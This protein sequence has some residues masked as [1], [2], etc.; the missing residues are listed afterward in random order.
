MKEHDAGL[1]LLAGNGV[2]CGFGRGLEMAHFGHLVGTD[3]DS[4]RLV[5]FVMM[6]VCLGNG[7]GEWGGTGGPLVRS[8]TSSRRANVCANMICL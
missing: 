2:L 6:Q 3:M 1:C 8:C 4:A 5:A 7:I